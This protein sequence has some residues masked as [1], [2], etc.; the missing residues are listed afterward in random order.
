MRA[1]RAMDPA[2]C[3]TDVRLV[4]KKGD[5]WNMSLLA[6]DELVQLPKFCGTREMRLLA[7]Q[8]SALAD[9]FD[10]D[11]EPLEVVVY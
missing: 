11:D 2:V 10:T 5:E 6:R 3:D 8:L 9:I 4:V 7:A 1:L